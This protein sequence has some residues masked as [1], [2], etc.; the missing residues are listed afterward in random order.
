MPKDPLGDKIAKDVTALGAFTNDPDMVELMAYMGFDWVAIDQMFTSIDWQKTEI[1]I[2]TAEAAGITPVVRIQSNPW[3]GYDP[4]LA[5]DATRAA[6]VGARYILV[7]NSGKKEIEDMAKVASDWHRKAMHIHPFKSFDEWDSK[8]VDLEAGTYVIPQPE[9]LGAL[10]EVEETL[11]LPHVKALF[12]AMTDAS[13]ELAGSNQPDWY[14]EKLWELVDRG[15][16]V[17]RENGA[18]IGANTSYAY[19]LPEL[20]KRVLRLSE[21]GVR[22]VL[23]QGAGF[24]F[25][26]AIQPFIDDLHEHLDS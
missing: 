23:I 2:R 24:L 7:S 25:Q 18:I 20:R 1:M 11:A 10:A 5:V 6:G 3:L 17:A 8:I 22:M 12:F 9:S 4:R 21:R 16:R 26:V 15:V 19:D 13:R 14:S